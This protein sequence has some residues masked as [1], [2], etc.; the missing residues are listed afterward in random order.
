M[1]SVI[2]RTE[3]SARG[4]RIFDWAQGDKFHKA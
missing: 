3:I 2:F 1:V 4:D